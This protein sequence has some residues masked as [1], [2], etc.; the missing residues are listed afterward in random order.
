VISFNTNNG[1]TY[2][3]NPDNV[4]AIWKGASSKGRLVRIY[5]TDAKM[6]QFETG[7]CGSD[8]SEVAYDKITLGG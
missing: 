6:Y 5:T 8:I 7:D 3:F 4:V 1:S 2:E